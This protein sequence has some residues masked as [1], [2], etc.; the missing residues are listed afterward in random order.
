MNLAPEMNDTA[1]NVTEIANDTVALE[2]FVDNAMVNENLSGF[3]QGANSGAVERRALLMEIVPEMKDTA[4]N[5]PA[6]NATIRDLTISDLKGK[7][8]GTCTYTSPFT[9][10][11]TCVQMTGSA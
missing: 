9:Q 2:E 8:A 5:L 11:P 6:G 10:P 3:P 1:G 4:G 7:G